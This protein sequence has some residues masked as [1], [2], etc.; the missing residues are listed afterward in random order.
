MFGEEVLPIYRAAVVGI[1]DRPVT[2]A[3]GEVGLGAWPA[4]FPLAVTRCSA[5]AFQFHDAIAVR[6][7]EHA[8]DAIIG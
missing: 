8:H 4:G 6:Q 2:E 3:K 1:Y 5:K 7:Q